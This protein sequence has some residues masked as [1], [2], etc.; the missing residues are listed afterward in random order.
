MI[1]ETPGPCPNSSCG[2][3]LVR[4][5][6]NRSDGW[7]YKLKRSVCNASV[8]DRARFVTVPW[9]EESEL[10]RCLEP[11][12]SCTCE[13]VLFYGDSTLRGSWEDL[14]WR[15]YDAG[16]WARVRAGQYAMPHIAP[17]FQRQMLPSVTC[18]C[19][20]IFDQVTRVSFGEALIESARQKHHRRYRIAIASSRNASKYT[21]LKALQTSTDLGASLFAHCRRNPT[22]GCASYSTILVG[23]GSWSILFLNDEQLFEQQ[24]DALL[25]SLR[26]HQP[27]AKLVVRLITSIGRPSRDFQGSADG[28]AGDFNHLAHDVYNPILRRLARKHCARVVDADAVL[29]AFPE[30]TQFWMTKAYNGTHNGTGNH[31]HNLLH[32]HCMDKE[33]TAAACASEA[34][35][36]LPSLAVAALIK[37]A[38]CDAAKQSSTF[39]A[40]R[41]H[42]L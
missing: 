23:V 8:H 35:R 28:R 34:A 29:A 30:M 38:V 20:H 36:S 12:P 13:R 21:Q 24:A 26:R 42:E 14:L 1:A 4:W 11:G 33:D 6:P 40:P 25:A 15:G 39:T 16:E 5:V 27:Q 22:L 31:V 17:S 3:Q 41:E 37:R 9:K 19:Q 2:D 32:F 7:P 10:Q 18:P